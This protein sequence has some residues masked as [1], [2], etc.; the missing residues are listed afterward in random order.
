M[1]VALAG[2]GRPAAT[3]AQELGSVERLAQACVEETTAGRQ[4]CQELS[5]AA[6]AVQ[7]GIGLASALGGGV[8]GSSS[9][10]GLRIGR[11][12]RIGLSAAGLAVR[13]TAP[14]VAGA[15]P[16]GLQERAVG[17][18]TGLKLGAAVGVLN[19]FQLG[20][21]VGGVLAVDVLGAYSLLRLPAAVGLDGWS[22][23]G[24]AGFRVGLLRESFTLPGVSVSAM[25]HWRGDVRSGADDAA[26][27]GS[28]ETG[29]TT[30]SL[31]ATV[32]KNWFVVGLLA[33]AGWDRYSGR[34]RVSVPGGG[35]AASVAEGDLRSTR[36]LYF[37]GAWLS[38]LVA[39][40]S[41]EAGMVEGAADP[42]DDRGGAFDPSAR[43]WFA[44]AAVRITP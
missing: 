32:G 24:G 21:N 22:S 25:R 28:V 30:T 42:F 13:M 38:Y 15:S 29:A 3:A 37:A 14:R 36:R 7:R 43:T 11:M 40:L 4:A 10:M 34:A 26:R 16:A 19:G 27:V 39:R 17:W 1:A 9:T 23:G 8:P 5:H 6:A 2:L 20:T 35:P 12:P 31:R 41:V 33:G 18:V 44:S